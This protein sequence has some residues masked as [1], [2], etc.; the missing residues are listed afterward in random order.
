MSRSTGR[1]SLQ[2]GATVASAAGVIGTVGAAA[3][4]YFARRV[5]TPGRQK[6][7]DLE[8]LRLAERS[9][10]MS[11]TVETKVPGRYGIWLDGGAGH[12]R[13][14]LILAATAT[15]VTRELLAVD[16][17]ELHTGP[18]RWNQYY[19][20][21]NPTTS[22]GLAHDDLL[23]DSE[24]GP[25]PVWRIPVAD[26]P[27]RA[28]AIAVHGLT[29]T[30]QECLRAI[31]PLHRL[32]VDVLVPSYRNDQDAPAD[33]SGR[34]HLGDDEWRDI[35]SVMSWALEQGA[36]EL[37]LIGW[38]MGGATVLATA[39]RSDLAEH[40]CALVL[41]GPVIDWQHVLDHNAQLRHIPVPVNRF[42]QWLLRNPVG[43]R[44]M[45]LTKPLDLR[46]LDSLAGAENLR[47]PILLIHSDADVYV[48]NR[49][50]LALAEARP[51]LVNLVPWQVGGHTK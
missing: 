32:G 5:I 18:A 27:T 2:V 12:A 9:V 43:H 48:P 21:G 34:Y 44:A 26:R 49:P 37:L 20:A 50:S 6:P 31:K 7:N 33:P 38:S 29:A 28:C 51:D 40:I 24:V 8:I 3:G 14:G 42:G 36:E 41:N 1:Q 10:T 23:I 46:R 39:Q 45:G 19:Y 22:L 25:L 47:H 30:R 17:G 16:F 4:G 35:E 15:E 11:A 13:V